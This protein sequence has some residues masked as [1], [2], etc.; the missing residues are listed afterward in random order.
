MR[1]GGGGIDEP[2]LLTTEPHGIAG[3][4]IYEVPIEQGAEQQ[5]LFATDP[6]ES[7]RRSIPFCAQIQMVR[8]S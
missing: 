7:T 8:V 2:T 4:F 6:N 5:F 3:H 1:A